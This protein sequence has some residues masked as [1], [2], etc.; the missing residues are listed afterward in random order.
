MSC[1]ESG[2]TTHIPPIAQETGD[3][4]IAH[5]ADVGNTLWTYA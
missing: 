4:V 5:V 2:C 3:R 1:A